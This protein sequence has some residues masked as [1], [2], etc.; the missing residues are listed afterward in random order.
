MYEVIL[1]YDSGLT[2][3]SQPID[4]VDRS[5]ALLSVVSNDLATAVTVIRVELSDAG[6]L[7]ANGV[8]TAL[9]GF[10]PGDVQSLSWTQLAAV[11]S[12]LSLN[13]TNGTQTASG[14]SAHAAVQY[15]LASAYV[16]VYLI[17]VSP[18]YTLA[19]YTASLVSP[20]L[21]AI[22]VAVLAVNLPASSGTYSW[23]IPEP[24]A[25][26]LELTGSEL[27]FFLSPHFHSNL[28]AS[29]ELLQWFNSSNSSTASP[30]G[31]RLLSCVDSLGCGNGNICNAQVSV[32]PCQCGAGLC[33][34]DNGGSFYG[35]QACCTH[36]GCP[37]QPPCCTGDCC[38]SDSNRCQPG[39]NC[40]GGGS[41]DPHFTTLDGLYYDFYGIGAYYLAQVVDDLSSFTANGTA[42]TTGFS[43]Q[44]ELLPLPDL[45]PPQIASW[46]GVT[47]THAIAMQ[48]S[49]LH[50]VIIIT[51]S[52]PSTIV[53]YIDGNQLTEPSLY[54]PSAAIYFDGGQVYWSDLTSVVVQMDSG[55][56]LTASTYQDRLGS[57]RLVM[58]F[59][60]FDRSVGLLGRW[61]GMTDLTGRNWYNTYTSTD[62]A[63]WGCMH[64]YQVPSTSSFFLYSPAADIQCQGA[65]VVVAGQCII[66]QPVA[67]SNA[68]NGSINYTLSSASPP[69]VVVPP[70]V[71]PDPSLQATAITS[72]TTAVMGNLSSPLYNACLTDVFASNTTAVAVATAQ[73]VITNTLQAEPSPALTLLSVTST[74]ATLSVVVNVSATACTAFYHNT[75]TL[76]SQA[77]SSSTI[78][79]L[80]VLQRQNVV[81]SSYGAVGLS[82]ASDSFMAVVSALSMA[83]AYTF[84]AAVLYVTSVQSVQ[85]AFVSLVVNTTGCAPTCVVASASG[86]LP[87]GSDGCGGS[88]GVCSNSTTY[89]VCNTATRSTNPTAYSSNT[90]TNR[91]DGGPFSCAR[92]ASASLSSSISSSP[93]S[94]TLSSPSSSGDS[95]S[96]ASPS[97]SSSAMPSSALSSSAVSSSAPASSSLSSSPPSSSLS[98]S[99]VSSSAASSSPLSFSVSSSLL[100]SSVQSSSRLSSSAVSSS[101]VSSSPLSS[102]ALSSSAA[103]SSAVSSS[104]VSSSGASSSPTSSTI[105]SALPAVSSST[106]SPPASSAGPS[107]SSTAAI[108]ATFF[109]NGLPTP[110]FWLSASSLSPTTTSVS[111]WPNLSHHCNAGRSFSLPS[112]VSSAYHGL[113][114]VR[115]SGVQDVQLASVYPTMADWSVVM[116]LA[117]TQ[118]L[119]SVYLLASRTS[120]DHSFLLGLS[121]TTVVWYSPQSYGVPSGGPAVAGAF[122]VPIGMP[123]VLTAT[124]NHATQLLRMYV[125]GVYLAQI[126]YTGATDATALLGNGYWYGNNLIGDVMDVLLFDVMLD[127][128]HSTTSTT[129]LLA[130]LAA[131]QCRVG[132]ARAAA[133]A[134]VVVWCSCPLRPSRRRWWLLGRLHCRCSGCQR[135]PS[136]HHRL[137]WTSGST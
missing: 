74:T 18:A 51:A 95:S 59:T 20:L 17:A 137:Q 98:S 50:S 89:S 36:C 61:N 83:S 81:D 30:Q 101:A 111:V 7:A 97:V 64:T 49:P 107:C 102:S 28:T 80:P 112:Y 120:D 127:D 105:T 42:I 91:T 52:L 14:D 39:Q 75:S 115:F 133:T 123:F 92:I 94:F 46:K 45:S 84:R 125:D 24:L 135:R 82:G 76:P 23:S 108:Y 103:S 69:V 122:G 93:L 1:S 41:G 117:V 68:I 34:V 114:A 128:R 73:L 121:P 88:C 116:V 58:P 54:G 19:G 99:V 129:A 25:S 110:L 100:S 53:V 113:P 21:T 79:C 35:C 85:L 43:A 71:W 15:Y 8:G 44:I 67:T 118:P 47:W 134:A 33:S 37:G 72:C 60:A 38:Q 124:Y 48:D 78:A 63:A 6:T 87:C 119:A 130:V 32:E 86:S 31:R 13:S 96:P 16:D 5:L 55:P 26:A 22:P 4:A 66:A 65:Q 109:P 131:A 11:T 77:N 10:Y 56:Q 2:F 104:A 90:L 9:Q 40:G 136:L 57:F 132:S 29:N 12:T 106:S 126:G 62:D 70:A 27:V 3:T